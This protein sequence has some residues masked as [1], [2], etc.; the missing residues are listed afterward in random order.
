V[1]RQW[2][3]VTPSAAGAWYIYP[4]TA[5]IPQFLHRKINI[6]SEASLYITHT[7]THTH[8]SCRPWHSLS[9]SLGFHDFLFN[10]LALCYCSLCGSRTCAA[11]SIKFSEAI[12][13]QLYIRRSISLPVPG[14]NVSI[15]SNIID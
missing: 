14:L 11:G 2:I 9:V 7:H 1:Q 3:Y 6:G 5:R 4:H 10:L 15:H 13:T 8:R 12:P